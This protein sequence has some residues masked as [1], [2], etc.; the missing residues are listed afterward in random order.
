[1]SVRNISFDRCQVSVHYTGTEVSDLLD[2]LFLDIQEDISLESTDSFHISKDA[3]KA[4]WTL[5]RDEK[6]LYC[7]PSLAGLGV[8]LMGEVLFH[9]IKDNCT[10]LAIHAGLVSDDT[11]TTLIPGASGN[12]KSSV[13]TWMLCQGMRYHTDELVTINLES[14]QTAPF[15]RPLNIKTRGV[16]PIKHIVDL[17]KIKDQTRVSAGVIM[18]P[19]RLVNPDFREEKPKITHI[20]F[21]KYIAD[22]TSE[23]VKLSGAEAGLELMRSNV[24]ARN[25]PTHGFGEVI[26]LVKNIP[27]Y[28]LNYSHYDD[29][30]N[31][32]PSIYQ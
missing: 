10:A 24:I 31:L 15:T 5:K 8:I 12:G 4:P 18:I 23:I 28:R 26:R 25:L 13:T 9:L 27:A 2:F 7:G 14:Q 11:S 32:I 17:D 1:M 21:P 30:D 20:L 3:E 16:E 22:S 29:L 19:H 6:S